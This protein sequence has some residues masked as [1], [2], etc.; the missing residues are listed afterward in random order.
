LKSRN[1]LTA[2]SFEINSNRRSIMSA[3]TIIAAAAVTVLIAPAPGSAQA[4]KGDRQATSDA[5]GA[6]AKSSRAARPA[7]RSR[8][9]EASPQSVVGLDGR[10]IGADPD[11]AI[12]FQLL[13][14]QATCRYR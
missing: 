9:A 8:V 10:V 13:R 4:L 12:R 3:K 11:A 1:S 6:A 5:Y 7:Q 14:D 2:S